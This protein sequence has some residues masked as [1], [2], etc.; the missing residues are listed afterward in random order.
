MTAAVALT[1]APPQRAAEVS[2]TLGVNAHI[3]YT[4]GGYRDLAHVV[5]S[6]DYIGVHN[7]RDAAPN[8]SN[9]GQGGYAALANA[10]VKFDLFV[11]G[12]AIAPAVRRIAQ[13]A[14]AAPGSVISIEGINEVNNHS[15]YTYGGFSDVHRSGA[16][17][18]AALY[19]EVKATPTLAHIPVIAFTDY[20]YTPG[21]SD[22]GNIHAYPGGDNAPGAV[23]AAGVKD[24][25][26]QV[27]GQ[28]IV[29]TEM[30]YPTSR[31]RPGVSQLAQARLLLIS[32]LDSA[33][34]GAQRTYIYELF[35][36]YADPKGSD[37]E[38]HF[39]VFNL[40]YSPKPAARMLHL[41]SA[42]YTDRAKAARTFPIKSVQLSWSGGGAGIRKLVV[43]KAD[44][45]IVAAVW[46][47][48]KIYD[49]ARSD[50]ATVEPV[51]VDLRLPADHGEV[52]INDPVA[53]TRG[54]ARDGTP[55]TRLLLGANPLIVQIAPASGGAA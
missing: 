49:F 33:A 23:L 32:L 22:V 38:K 28:P 3:E 29:F 48:L 27:P 45:E 54:V 36:A 7:V 2:S 4:D 37:Q 40:D 42:I 11:N 55:L 25:A 44:G 5:N 52:T 8:P 12:E 19:A 9:Q 24:T 31:G 18:Q 43:Q 39:G 26:A 14:R 6:L 21:R 30:G 34:A 51:A 10:G 41:V 46:R 13:L 53:A 17:F 1:L 47:E 20:P 16:A 50:D 35:D 15:G